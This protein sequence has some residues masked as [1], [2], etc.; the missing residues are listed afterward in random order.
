MFVKEADAVVIFPGGFGTH[1]ELSESLTLAQTGKSQIVP[2]V[3][4]DLPG[5]G[6]WK[7]WERCRF[8]ALVSLKGTAVRALEVVPQVVE[9]VGG[10]TLGAV[11]KPFAS[12]LSSALTREQRLLVY[13]FYP[14]WRRIW[15]GKLDRV[16]LLLSQEQAERSNLRGSINTR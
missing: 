10:K 1:D 14:T 16:R 5:G 6:Y 15:D 7:E 3:L 8:P 13:S 9:L 4:M 11:A 2:I 12:A